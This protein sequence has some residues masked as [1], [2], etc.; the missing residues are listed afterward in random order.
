MTLS[1]CMMFRHWKSNTGQHVGAF[2]RRVAQLQ[3]Q[4]TDLHQ[5]ATAAATANSEKKGSF[6]VTDAQGRF[7]AAQRH[8]TALAR[9]RG[10]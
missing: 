7:S 2:L 9:P 10:D 1:P 8:L 6:P 4:Q 3:D 5:Q